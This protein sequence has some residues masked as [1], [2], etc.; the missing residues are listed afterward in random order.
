MLVRAAPAGGVAGETVTKR[1]VET[2]GSGPGRCHWI[3]ADAGIGAARVTKRADRSVFLV[4]GRM[5][6]RTVPPG[7]GRMRSVHAVAAEAG[8]S[9]YAAGKIGSMAR[10]TG[11]ETR[12]VGLGKSA[13]RCGIGPT[14]GMP[15]VGIERGVAIPAAAAGQKKSAN[16]RKYRIHR[17]LCW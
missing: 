16:N 6:P 4:R 12:G 5:R 1:T 9:R 15:G 11:F 7:S 14:H 3:R 17:S 8:G 2:P 13:V 10:S